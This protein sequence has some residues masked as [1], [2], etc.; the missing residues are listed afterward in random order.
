MIAKKKH[1]SKECGDLSEYKT[2]KICDE[3][4]PKKCKRYDSGNCSYKNL[5]AYIHPKPVIDKYQ[6]EIN[7]KVKKMEIVVQALTRKVQSLEEEP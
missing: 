2:I 4:H 6:A 3:R 1:F 7:E 5:C